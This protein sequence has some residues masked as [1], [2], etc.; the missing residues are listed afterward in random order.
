MANRVLIFFAIGL[1][2][3]VSIWI[4]LYSGVQD[5]NGASEKIRSLGGN[6]QLIVENY[7]NGSKQESRK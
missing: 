2:I 5:Y 1:I 3:L 6:E 7:L 4:Y